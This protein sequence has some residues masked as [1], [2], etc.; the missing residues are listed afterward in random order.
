MELNFPFP[1]FPLN[2]RS[3]SSLMNQQI[4]SVGSSAGGMVM[5]MRYIVLP[6]IIAS[7]LLTILKS[8]RILGSQP[9]VRSKGIKGAVVVGGEFFIS[10]E[11]LNKALRRW[12]AELPREIYV[13]LLNEAVAQVSG[14]IE[15]HENACD[16][17]LID[18]HEVG[19]ETLGQEF[20]RMKRAPEYR[21]LWIKV[22]DALKNA[23][24]K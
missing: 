9:L 3:F 17:V 23:K 5:G 2:D 12:A 16:K 14:I 18:L 11:D 6:L 22:T 4:D 7:L 8:E 24:K 21:H 13:D 1:S 10:P 15:Q 20:S 19:R